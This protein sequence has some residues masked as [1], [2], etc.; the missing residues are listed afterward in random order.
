MRP[1]SFVWGYMAFKVGRGG[2]ALWGSLRRA[3]TTQPECTPRYVNQPMM[4]VV[5]ASL[6][7][8]TVDRM[9]DIPD[10]GTHCDRRQPS[11]P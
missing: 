5:A 6:L 10:P 3:E 7:A 4:S 2:G 11:P 1:C 8:M 9:E